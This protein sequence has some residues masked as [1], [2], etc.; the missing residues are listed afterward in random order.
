MI[1]KI[2][3]TT[4]LVFIIILSFEISVQSQAPNIEWQKCLGNDSWY[5]DEGL[6]IV[7][8]QGNNFA[9][10]GKKTEGGNEI[11]WVSKMNQKGEILWE[12]SLFDRTAYN[13][14][15]AIDMI[16]K[17]DGS[18][19]LLAQIANYNEV[20]FNYTIGQ[21]STVIPQK[22]NYDVIVVKLNS[23]GQMTW[24]KTFGGSGQDVPVKILE[25]NDNKYILLTHTGS[26][27]GDMANSGKNTVG[28]NQDLWFAK[29]DIDGS[30]ISK[31]CIGGDKDDFG[32]DMKKTPDGKFIIVGSTNSDD[33]IIGPNKGDKDAFIIKTDD[34]G[35]II[36]QKTFGGTQK[37][38]AR[39]VLIKDN[40]EIILGINSNSYNNYFQFTATADFPYN[41]EE[42]IWL[43]NLSSDGVILKKN[44]FGGANRDLLANIILSKDK[45]L[46]V[47]G[48]T[49]SNN[50]DIQDRNRIPNNNN[51]R[52]DVLLMKISNEL[53]LTWERTAGGSSD[54]EGNGVIET[55]DDGFIVLGTTQSFDGDVKG[56]H[57]SPQ[58]NRDIWLSKYRYPC[59]NTLL[60]DD[61]RT[62]INKKF[63]AAQT[64][65]TKDKILGQSSISYGAGKSIDIEPGFD[66]GVGSSVLLNLEGCQ[67]SESKSNQ[68]IQIK[69]NNE[70]REG[71]MKFKFMPFTPNTDLS[72][73]R[74]SIQNNSPGVE[75]DFSGNIL[76]TKNNQPNPRTA[77][78]TLTVSKDGFDDFIYQSYTSTCEHDNAPINCPENN[79]T[80]LLD[81]E[82]YQIG[83]TFRA[84][85]TGTL[86][87]GQTLNWYNEGVSEINNDPNQKYF[88]GKISYFPAH[89]QAQPSSLPDGSRP[90][91]GAS[92]V[93]FR[94]VKD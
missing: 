24:F 8:L 42:T 66:T 73:Y 35:N 56:N 67:P 14:F 12:T 55:N 57:Y 23:E 36:W 88:I 10:I 81:K 54:D 71:G 27:D 21:Y 79:N 9:A 51:D 86:L 32:F 63:Q 34:S 91:H 11:V 49:K 47:I 7:P 33:A 78:F 77:Y 62:G 38:E 13:G 20:F 37:D 53:D 48:S 69:I 44:K 58:D 90:C 16:Q 74:M 6:K 19:V 5:G 70:C 2:R 92:R 89:I 65:K 82:Y 22:G 30:I 60:L 26:G 72:Q 94:P 3:Y 75:Y 28:Y 4:L 39:C 1:K 40:S 45:D 93:E 85:W 50:G 83:E 17:S 87:P 52:F 15:K 64:I 68:P 84:T 25:S 18:Y 31:K 76:I 61:R 41:Y 43:L 46:I 80:V 29:L 59:E